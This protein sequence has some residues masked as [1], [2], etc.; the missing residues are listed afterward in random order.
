MLASSR[1]AF[2]AQ[3]EN[4]LKEQITELQVLA[5]TNR[6]IPINK[7]TQTFVERYLQRQ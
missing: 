4:T 2:L 3:P 7:A 6:S 1:Y 5:I